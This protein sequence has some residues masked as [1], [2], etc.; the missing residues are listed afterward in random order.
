MTVGS[1]HLT[2][3]FRGKIRKAYYRIECPCGWVHETHPEN[4]ER[5]AKLKAEELAIH[6][7]LFKHGRG[8]LLMIA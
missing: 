3:R 8:Y 4:T 5:Q 7:N 1:I 2:K 6:H